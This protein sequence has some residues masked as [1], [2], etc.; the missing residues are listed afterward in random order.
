[1]PDYSDE[2]DDIVAAASICPDCD[3]MAFAYR[4]T[5]VKHDDSDRWEF[6]CARCGTGFT[7]PKSELVF[8]SLPKEWLL[9]KVYAA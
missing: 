6:M 4:S 1:L 7:M 8:E 3:T 9:A 5:D 2:L